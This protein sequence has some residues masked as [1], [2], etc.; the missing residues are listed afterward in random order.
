L[1]FTCCKILGVEP[2][3][4]PEVIKSAFRKSAKELHPDKNPSE[5]AEYYFILI[6]NAYQYLIDHPYSKEEIAYMEKLAKISDE[7]SKSNNH[8][9]IFSR[10]PKE[11]SYTLRQVLKNS[12]T[13]RILFIFFHIIFLTIGIFLI[14]KPIS[15]AI[16][17]PVDERTSSIPAYFTLASGMILGIIITTIFLFSGYN[18]LRHR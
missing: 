9:K 2:G 15:D 13:A 18:Y 12:L 10:Y 7:E 8:Q 4:D 14:V 1:Y 11:R 16:L 6:K 5:K 3:S 17:Y